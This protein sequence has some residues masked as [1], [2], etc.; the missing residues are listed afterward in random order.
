MA[1]NGEFTA[2]WPFKCEYCGDKVERGQTGFYVFIH[3]KKACFD[4]AIDHIEEL[5]NGKR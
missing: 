3:S 1:G 5:R 4:C 2:K